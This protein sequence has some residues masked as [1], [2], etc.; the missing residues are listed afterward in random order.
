M[1][2]KQSLL[3]LIAATL[4]FV[5]A[6]P[7]AQAL[8]TD[9]YLKTQNVTRN[10]SPNVLIILDNSGSMSD[11]VPST[12]PAYD[13]TV[14]YCNDDL[15][16][17][18]GMSGSNAG[19][20]SNCSSI[21]NQIF[22]TFNSTPPAT[23]D[24]GWFASSKN[25]CLASL[26]TLN[27]GG[28]GIYASVKIAMWKSGSN[29]GTLRSKIDSDI[30][31]VDCEA[32]GT[33]NGQTTGDGTYPRSSTSTAYTSSSTAF[34]WSGFTTRAFPTLYNANYMNYYNN[35]QLGTSRPKINIA[36]DAVN[37]LINANKGIRFGL[38]IFNTNTDSDSV[39][40]G[41][42]GGRVMVKVDNMD[43]ARRAYMTD[44]VSGIQAETNTPLAETMWE[45]YRYLSGNGVDYG[46]NNPLLTVSS[47]T[48]SGSTATVTTSSNHGFSNGDL[49]KISGATQTEYNGG[50]YVTV[51]NSTRFTYTVSGAPTTPATGTIRATLFRDTT[52]ESGSNYVTPFLFACQKT[53]VV[54][55]TDGDP[56]NDTNANANIRART[57]VSSCKSYGGV[58][59]CLADL[60][61]WMWNNDVV[62]TLYGN[63]TVTTYTV[64]FGSGISATG[65]ALLQDA[66]EIRKTDGTC[67]K[68]GSGSYHA[69]TD[70]DQLNSALQT[71]IQGV[72]EETTSF[73]AP[74]LSINAFNKQYNNSDVY[75]SV[76]KPGSSC[77]WDGNIKKY[78]LCTNADITAGR[79]TSLSDV[80]DSNGNKITDINNNIIDSAKSY[81]SAA[82][83]GS[84][85]N[86][87]GA[88]S[89][90]PTPAARTLY[91]YTGSYSGLTSP[92]T[93]VQI[94]TTTGN[95]FYDAVTA[96]P[97][98]LGL[99]GGSTSTDVNKLVNWM[100]GAD[101]YDQF[102][103]APGTTP[104]VHTGNTTEPRD[105]RVGDPL[106]SR[107]V[108]ITFGC[109]GSSTTCTSTSTPVTKLFV[110]ANDG[111]VRMINNN[112]GV[113]EWAFIP[114]ELYSVQYQL[115]QGADADHV[116]GLDGTP[117]FWIKDINNDGII[118]QTAGDRV[119]M[120]MGMRRG[121]RSIYA[122]DVTPPS[123]LTSTST[124]FTPKLMWV[125]QGGSGN[126]AQLGETWSQPK[127][128]RV[129]YA[130][131]PASICDDSNPNTNDTNSRVVLIFGGGY[132]TN[133]DNA[134]PA[135]T[136]AMGNAIYIVDPITGSRLWWASSAATSGTGALNLPKMKFSIPSDLNL[137]DSDGNGTIDRMYVGDTGGQL[138]RFDLGTVPKADDSGGP[139]AYVFADLGCGSG[140][141]HDSSGACP[142]AT[143]AQDRRKFFYPPEVAPIKD[144]TYSSNPNY[145]L[146]AI[147][148]GDREDPLDLLT[149][150][151]TSPQTK[152]AVH[153]RIYALRDYNYQT[154]APGTAPTALTEA[155][156]Y[157]ATANNLAT[158]TGASLQSEI[159]TVKTKKGWFIN[160]KRTAAIQVPNGI[161]TTWVG[162]KVLAKATIFDGV[163][164]VTT[165]TP[166]N[167]TDNTTTC[168][169]Q[170]G[171]A[172]EYAMDA[173][174]AVG[175]ADFNN[176][177]TM[178]RSGQIGGGIPSEVVIV[179]RPDGTTGLINAGGKGGAPL[180]AKGISSNNNART[181]WYEE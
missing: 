157:D 68:D 164:H 105:W 33:T 128:A 65:L 13:P 57:G 48:R 80:L 165:F 21:A 28:G 111:T 5:A 103:D 32:D 20:P 82:A 131:S 110:G 69:A 42:H 163:L 160:L 168:T 8:D 12:R 112:T 171:I 88:G 144:A 98:L 114:Q 94:V 155:D 143:T 136:D 62:S 86:K 14:D 95:A 97:S 71:I 70:A 117:S 149:S 7:S 75:L 58:T 1:K 169:P 3:P 67:C 89:V 147:G 138:W 150:A 126:F 178:D 161:T 45:A 43:D 93:G 159:D 109:V 140:S 52:A 145:D 173:L 181:Y 26:S 59:S 141:V 134:I 56:T 119:Y 177:G 104:A 84:D 125:I 9:V 180:G 49:V 47:I 38:M 92:S 55:V 17:V 25:K 2:T 19:K 74:S 30:T 154:G 108:P 66:A 90:M 115:S 34:S 10:D 46:D 18:L 127:I 11:S 102:T 6:V 142:S 175:A 64:G 39:S 116:Y 23:T 179:I 113:E 132:D 101:A 60:T 41:N 167:T 16:T 91:T 106:H 61:H 29:W 99:P 83:D 166:P 170:E 22:F 153:N 72:L 44:L 148:S 152:E 130:C 36:K 151:L 53:N 79:C 50:F 31:Y 100:R 129:P 27:S 162:E 121:G 120:F 118:N 73:T 63:Q 37:Q 51:V 81:W 24:N 40:T 139:K 77:A 158:L 85:V 96:S 124:T 137:I 35:S 76:F 172:M 54:L 122:F 135:G 133:Q 15:D 78:T 176:D 174:S 107:A 87:G 146:V 156:M 123:V 4:S